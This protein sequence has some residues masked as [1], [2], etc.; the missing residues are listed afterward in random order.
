[1]WASA[2]PGPSSSSPKQCKSDG[3]VKIYISVSARSPL[4]RERSNIK[5][6]RVSALTDSVPHNGQGA[7]EG[8]SIHQESNPCLPTLCNQS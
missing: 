8:F 3:R 4:M 7:A 1:M 5:S 6:A 2:G